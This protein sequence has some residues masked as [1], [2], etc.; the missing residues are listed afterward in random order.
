MIGVPCAGC[1]CACFGSMQECSRAFCDTGVFVAV[2]ILSVA[3]SLACVRFVDREHHGALR[4]TG[5]S[6]R[7]IS[8]RYRAVKSVIGVPCAGCVCA[9]F[10]SMHVCSRALCNTGV[11]VAVAKLSVSLSLACVRF[12][13]RKHHGALRPTGRSLRLVLACYRAV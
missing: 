4:R 12:V 1:V 2:A 10:G 11:F 6:S 7:L 13:D 5:R 3:L 8:A 9:C